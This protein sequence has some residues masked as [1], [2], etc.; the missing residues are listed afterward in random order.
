MGYEPFYC[1]IDGL[2]SFL[3][4]STGT[5]RRGGKGI[6]ATGRFF[7]AAIPAAPPD[8]VLP[9][10]LPATSLSLLLR[11]PRTSQELLL[12]VNDFFVAR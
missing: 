2:L 8:P 12:V 5:S 6:S 7:S 3:F 10:F 9:S 4:L 1:L 11:G